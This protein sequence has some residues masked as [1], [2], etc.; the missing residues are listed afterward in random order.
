MSGLV[1]GLCCAVMSVLK[2]TCWVHTS[3]VDPRMIQVVGTVEGAI[4]EGHIYPGG[5]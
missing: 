5:I 1:T 3:D 2:M 4:L